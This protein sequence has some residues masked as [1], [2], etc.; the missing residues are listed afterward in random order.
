M[1]TYFW[2]G[3]NGTWDAST[4]T[5][6]ALSSGGAGGAGFP[7]SADS[8]IFD[9][10]SGAAPVVTVS[11]AVC[12]ACTIGAPTSGTLTLDF[13]TSSLTMAGNLTVNT[14]ISV[15]GTGTINLSAVNSTFAGNGN[16]FY[17][18]SFTSASLGSATINGANTFN[19]VTFAN[20][21]D[22]NVRNISFSADQI[23][24]GTLTLP[25]TATAYSRNFLFSNTLGTQRT[26][27][28]N[29]VAT[30]Q[31]VDFRDIA[32]AGNCI[33]GGNLTGTRLGDCLNNSGITFAA[34]VNK[35]Y[36][37][38]TGAS[39]FIYSN[40]WETTSGG[41][42]PSLNNF[43]LAQDTIVVQD[44]GLSAGNTFTI[45]LRYN[46]GSVDFST[47]TLAVNF[48][49]SHN[50]SS[51]YG[52]VTLSS[53]VT[54][55]GTAG[56]GISFI[57]QG[58]TQNITSAGV[59]VNFYIE[60]AS[61]NGT[62]KLIDNFTSTSAT[63]TFLTRGTLDLNNNTLTCNLFIS[64]NSNTRS[65][66][67][68]TG[69]ITVIG[70]A[71]T[72]WSCG[73]LTGFS[74]TGTPTVNC[75]Y[76]GS[77][78]TRTINS[79]STTGG[80][81]TNSPN[82]NISAGTDIVV[83]A[84][85]GNF[86]NLNFSGFTGTLNANNRNIYG[87]L[88]LDAGM[89]LTAGANATSF[90]A[91]SGTQ[92]ITTNGKTLD[93]PLTQNSLGATVQLQDNLTMGS[94]RTFTLTAGA[95]DLSSGNRTLSAGLF[96]SNNGNTRSIAFG[97]GNITTTG[98]GTVWNTATVTNFS[99]TGTPTVNISNNS[100]TA[101]TVSTGAM[102]EAQSLNFNYTIGTY[103]V[104]DTAASY[105]SVNFTGFSGTI[106]NSVR[107]IFGS[108]TLSTGMT[109][110]AGT[111]ATTFASTSAGNTIT[112]AGKTQDYPIIFDGI[113][114]TF[115]FQDAL[116][117]GSTR[118]FT[119]T[120]GTVEL[121]DGVTS[122]VGAF[123]TSGTNQKFLQST[124]PGS[125]ATLSQ[126][127]GTVDASYLTIRDINAVGGATWNAFVNQ[128]NIDAGNNDGWDFGISP[129]VGSYEYTYQLRSFTQPRRF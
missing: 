117:Q 71:A 61:L 47:R 54:T 58:K 72:V 77:T 99:R 90:L 56:A 95:L 119:I 37:S 49:Q 25:A 115:A 92:Q 55:T 65:I 84:S 108:L 60:I 11:S 42:T 27:T 7:T 113:G 70:N 44:T 114:G 45:T 126:A 120:N 79:G 5:N 110:T 1:A 24:N 38:A 29:A 6:W 35:Y 103:T 46:I 107:T 50:A 128:Q 23:I 129:I 105:R 14:T 100:A 22:I 26:L 73:N 69:N 10:N 94:T 75:T 53:A 41:T 121:K 4:T 124:T 101:T 102:T 63:A 32:F 112:N 21:T 28:C 16:T 122:T 116:T 89:T 127:S 2:V 19:N 106:P 109:L 12:S 123:A 98:S 39:G 97:T 40:V 93:F 15:A 111:N 18:V 118:A 51:Y 68:G 87:N 62:V 59:S 67:F 85:T 74:Y 9:A 31:N 52:D 81:E 88:T 3:G 17:N 80:T 13:A 20:S 43:P 66:S 91:T 82:F 125:Q 64:N 78:G 8:V 86:K 30:L 57:G 76:S 33:S 34:G 83:T 48:A 96:A 36:Y 104:T